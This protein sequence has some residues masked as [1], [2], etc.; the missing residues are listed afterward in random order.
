[1]R[2]TEL[3]NVA[4]KMYQLEQLLNTKGEQAFTDRKNNLINGLGEFYKDFNA[5]VDEK[6]FEQLIELYTNKS[7]KQFVGIE[8]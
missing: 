6:V 2:N 7:P 3:L 4:Y 1:M 5:G 8:P